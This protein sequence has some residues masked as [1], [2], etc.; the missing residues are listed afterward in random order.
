MENL[1]N[2]ISNVIAIVIGIGT[3]IA[4]ALEGLPSDSQWYIVIGAVAVA[5]VSWLTGKPGKIIK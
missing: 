4:A 5:I 3:A 2:I 1:K